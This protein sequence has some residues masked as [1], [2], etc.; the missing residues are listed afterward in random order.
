MRKS[1]VFLFAAAFIILQGCGAVRVSKNPDGDLTAW[2]IS[3]VGTVQPAPAEKAFRVTEGSASKGLTL[4]SP[5]TFGK[6]AV[7]RFGVKPE[8]YEGVCVVLLSASDKNTGGLAVPPNHDGSLGF[9]SEGTVQ[10][11]M[12]A[13]HTGFH[14]PNMYIK[15]NP[16]MND[17][18]QAKDIAAG[19]TWYDMEIGRAGAR[20]WMKVGGKIVLEGTDPGS[21]LPGGYIGIRLRGPGDGSFSCLFRDLTVREK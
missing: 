3:G 18:A 19:Q 11:Y 21:G 14:Q 7:V 5:R 16:G 12:F 9:W 13:F 8:R 15:R 2:R 4:V 17:I 10:N 1:I 6:N 20:L